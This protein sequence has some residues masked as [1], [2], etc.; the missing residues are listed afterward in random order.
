MVGA[1]QTIMSAIGPWQIRDVDRADW[2]VITD[3]DKSGLYFDKH[4]SPR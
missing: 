2:R 3:A 4:R 1:I